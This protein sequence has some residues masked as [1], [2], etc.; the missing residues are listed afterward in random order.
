MVRKCHRACTAGAQCT[1]RPAAACQRA[2]WRSV[3]SPWQLLPAGPGPPIPTHSAQRSTPQR[4]C[5]RL[6]APTPALHA[7]PAACAAP[8]PPAVPH[9]DLVRLKHGLLRAVHVPLLPQRLGLRQQLVDAR[10]HSVQA[11]LHKGEGGMRRVEVK[12][13][14]GWDGLGA[15]QVSGGGMALCDTEGRGSGPSTLQQA[16]GR[17]PCVVERGPMPALPNNQLTMP[18][19]RWAAGSSCPPCAMRNRHANH[20]ATS[21]HRRH[22]SHA[23]QTC[24]AASQPNPVP[25]A[26]TPLTPRTP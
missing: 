10:R 23:S 20:K 21:S 25:S 2:A 17:G 11:L 16:R 13:W 5:S 6:P 9:L 8:A 12:W 22:S 19:A 4:A 1:A 24:N 14:G 3:H 26:P 15:R 18:A 7:A